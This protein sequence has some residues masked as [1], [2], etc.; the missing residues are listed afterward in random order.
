[1]DDFQQ[2]TITHLIKGQRTAIDLIG[3]ESKFSFDF[4]IKFEPD[5]DF[6][7]YCV[8]MGYQDDV[9]VK[10]LSLRQQK[11]I[12]KIKVDPISK[13]DYFSQRLFLQFQAQQIPKA[14]KKF[15]FY[16]SLKENIQNRKIESAQLQCTV[17]KKGMLDECYTFDFKNCD[18]GGQTRSISLFEVYQKGDHWRLYASAESRSLPLN[19]V[20]TGFDI[21]QQD[22]TST[23]EDYFRSVPTFWAFEA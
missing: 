14:F 6:D 10:Q 8:M 23:T 3:G 2:K 18:F 20:M 13:L 12:Q 19:E 11:E 4:D 22:S 9:S 21:N 5:V 7:I 1:M 15:V 17:Q 16:L